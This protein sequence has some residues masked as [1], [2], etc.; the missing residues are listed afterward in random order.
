MNF[1]ASDAFRVVTRFVRH[2]ECLA[3]EFEV[4]ASINVSAARGY[5]ACMS[6]QLSTR[7]RPQTVCTGSNHANQ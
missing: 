2:V 4:L 6:I 1:G 5:L 7:L 3:F